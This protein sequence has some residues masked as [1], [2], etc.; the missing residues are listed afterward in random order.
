MHILII[1]N[2][3]SL[4]TAR[5]ANSLQAQGHKVYLLSHR[6][7]MG[8]IKYDAGIEIINF[9]P[10][11]TRL[12]NIFFDQKMRSFNAY[13]DGVLHPANFL[14]LFRLL[15]SHIFPK[16]FTHFQKFDSILSIEI[17]MGGLLAAR[18]PLQVPKVCL[19]LG[20]DMHLSQN[21]LIN[22]L[23]LWIKRKAINGNTTIITGNGIYYQQLF[24]NV[25]Q[26]T[27]NVV[28][29][30]AFG[31]EERF[32][33]APFD[34]RKR[35]YL[36]NTPTDAIIAVCFRPVRTILDFERMIRVTAT[37]VSIHPNFRLF[38]GTGDANVD[39]LKKLA[40][41][42]EVSENVHFLANIDYGVL[43]E[44]YQHADIYMDA[45][46][47]N[48]TPEIAKNGISLSTVEAMAC[49]LIPVLG[50]QPSIGDYIYKE[51]EK[52]VFDNSDEDMVKKVLQ[53]ITLIKN[54][55]LRNE[56]S[57][58][59]LTRNSWDAYV[60]NLISLLTAKK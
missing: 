59:I 49:G 32:A 51:T 21:K 17:D 50:Y 53:A 6:L 46:N 28:Y 3:E 4:F 5:F 13:S 1:A 34:A 48:K 37:I 19:T 20:S 56:I 10:W 11:L 31:V 35:N 15:Y 36:Y 42:L 33:A 12:F 45:T 60:D 25:F 9:A 27:H 24:K 58:F 26:I 41:V 47:V 8:Q 16:S 22:R 29:K 40:A 30:G 55:E 54:N 18:I 14:T 44:Y 23:Q 2:S 7:H 38:I 52:L 57:N 43:H 39:N